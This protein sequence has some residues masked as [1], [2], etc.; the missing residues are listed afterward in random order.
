MLNGFDDENIV[1]TNLER[2]SPPTNFGK[3]YATDLRRA[4]RVQVI[5]GGHAIHIQLHADGGSVRHVVASAGQGH[6]FFV[7]AR[8]YVLAA[9]GLENPRLLL[10]SDDVHGNGI[11]NSTDLIGRFYMSHL[12]SVA[13]KITMAEFRPV[14]RSGFEK[15]HAGVYVRRRFALT[16]GA[17]RSHQIGNAIALLNRPQISNAIHRDPLLSSAFLAKHYMDIIGRRSPGAIVSELRETSGIQREHWKVIAGARADTVYSVLQ[18]LRKRYLSK[19][20]LPSVLG[21]PN[22]SQHYISYQTEHAPNRDSRIVLTRDRDELGMRRI[23]A[24]AAFSDIDI[25]TVIELHRL[26][27]E[28]FD[29]TGYGHVDFEEAQLREHISDYLRHFNSQAH[30]LGTTRMSLGP[31]NGVVD[32][33][34]EVHGVR[35]LFVAGA[36]VFPTGGYANPTL[37][38]VALSV[39]LAAYLGKQRA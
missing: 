10:T 30:H 32:V 18:V 21:T 33:N 8:S 1:S 37:T 3:R 31:A 16:P 25:T 36:S 39:R 26:L 24:R 28:R 14:L 23:T 15:D 20:R 2:W 5:M 38:I 29:K 34:C 35:G 19:R 4:P 22:A 12:T 17:Q 11:G 9:G 6:Q 27:A 7:E 13:M